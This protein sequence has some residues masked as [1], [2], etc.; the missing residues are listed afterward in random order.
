MAALIL[1]RSLEKQWAATGSI[2]VS[3]SN[4]GPGSAPRGPSSDMSCPH[5]CMEGG[6][7]EFRKAAASESRLPGFLAQHGACAPRAARPVLP[8]D[9]LFA[10]ARPGERGPAG[11]LGW[12]NGRR[13]RS[14]PLGKQ[15]RAEQGE[16]GTAGLE[17]RHGKARRRCP[18]ERF[19]GQRLPP[20]SA[21]ASDPPPQD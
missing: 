17:W 6:P 16:S 15:K 20:T 2:Y 4:I 14:S 10:S 19:V 9:S 1:I 7:R 5:Y 11:R 8:R 21:A 12:V 13:R 18:A 3:D